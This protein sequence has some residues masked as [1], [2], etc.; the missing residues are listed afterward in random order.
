MYKSFNTKKTT[1]KVNNESGSGIAIM[2]KNAKRKMDL[3]GKSSTGQ[4]TRDRR[5]C[6]VV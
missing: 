5:M 1:T 4:E 6:R 2:M 3:T